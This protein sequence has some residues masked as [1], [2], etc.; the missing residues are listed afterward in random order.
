MYMLSMSL[1]TS[2][3]RRMMERV[4][5]RPSW[6]TERSGTTE[7]PPPC[8]DALHPALAPDT[9][10][11]LRRRRDVRVAGPTGDTCCRQGHHRIDAHITDAYHAADHTGNERVRAKRWWP[12]SLSVSAPLPCALPQYRCLATPMAHPTRNRQLHYF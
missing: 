10:V 12:Q 7:T 5:S 6:W 2:Q 1:I 3:K 9:V 8:P 11:R 4:L